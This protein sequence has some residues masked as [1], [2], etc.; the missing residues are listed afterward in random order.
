MLKFFGVL[1]IAGIKILD[2]INAPADAANLWHWVSAMTVPN[3][4]ILIIGAFTLT[5]FAADFGW[6]SP[7]WNPFRFLDFRRRPISSLAD[8]AEY[9]GWG[10]SSDAY[11]VLHR[12]FRQA[13][14]DGRI[15]LWGRKM[16]YSLPAHSIDEPLV[17]IPKDHWHT[18]EV[19]P[20]R[21]FLGD[22]HYL[23]SVNKVHGNGPTRNQSYVDI[24]ARRAVIAWWV[25]RNW[26]R[27]SKNQVQI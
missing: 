4:L 26:P 24:Q 22:G 2:Y 19:P 17:P 20:D 15:K 18:F 7:K 9:Q 12:N 11:T 10:K 27:R 1:A 6:L 25:L 5:G 13:S 3:I 23:C 8:E 21:L 14:A 16:I